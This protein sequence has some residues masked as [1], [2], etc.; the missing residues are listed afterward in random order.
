MDLGEDGDLVLEVLLLPDF[1]L[2]W[3]EEGFPDVVIS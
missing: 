1:M 3:V 2:V